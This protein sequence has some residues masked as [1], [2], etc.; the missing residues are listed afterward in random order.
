MADTGIATRASGAGDTSE[1]TL[2]VERLRK[3]SE[4]PNGCFAVHLHLSRLRASNKQPHFL[5]IAKRSFD[6]LV[7]N[8]ESTLFSLS[9]C[10]IV[11]IC[12]NVPVDDLDNPIN[13]VRG[14]FREDPVAAID[15]S[16]FEEDRFTTWYDLASKDDRANFV[17]VANQL[18]A[19]AVAR[20]KKAA[21]AAGAESTAAKGTPLTPTNLADINRKILAVRIADLIREQAAVL[22]RAGGKGQILFRENFVAM[23]E[24][25]ERVA[26]GV[27]LFASTWLFQ[28]LTE[29]LD[30][31]VLAVMAQRNFATMRDPLSLNLNVGT[32]LSRDFQPFHQIV[33]NHAAKVVVEMQVVDIFADMNTFAF[34]RDS[35]QQRGY[36]VLVDGLNP[37]SLQFFDPS[38]LKADFVKIAW[39]PEF[40][41]ETPDSRLQELREVVA[42]TGKDA[43]II[44]R[45]DSEQAIK[46]GLSLGI[47]RFQGR[48]IDRL[49]QAAAWQGPR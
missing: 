46:W 9:N 49:V 4:N 45:V 35:L 27:N 30:K 48:F 3:V 32:V 5:D 21:A 43:V 40:A 22:V 37:L 41:G 47:T 17:T 8:A 16:G 33:G 15:D 13:K 2:L 31:R 38:F 39:G 19:D 18:L 7:M 29:T 12:R 11:V 24:L 1:E 20:K 25:K 10:D 6:P 36:R 26:P 23:A 14:L 42:H 34:A 28:F 44:S